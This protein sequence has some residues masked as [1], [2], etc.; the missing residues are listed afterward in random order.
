VLEQ[1][2]RCFEVFGGVEIV[3]SVF[4]V[5]LRCFVMFGKYIECAEDIWKCLGC[6]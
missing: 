4:R 2:G 1:L 3:W 5:L 6:F